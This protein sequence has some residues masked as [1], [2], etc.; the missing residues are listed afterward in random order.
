M[1]R[2]LGAG[3]IGVT[4]PFDQVVAWAAEFGFEGVSVPVDLAVDKG[5]EEVTLPLQKHKIKP[6]SFGLPVEYRQDADVFKKEVGALPMKAEIAAQIG[7]TRCT[8]WVLPGRKGISDADYFNEL[9]DRLGECAKILHDHGIRIGFEYLGPKTL[10]DGLGMETEGINTAEKMMELVEA[11]GI[12]GTGLLLDSW[13]WY[14]A[15]EDTKVFD[16]LNNRLVIAVHV[17]DAPRD[18]AIDEQ[19]DN[20]RDL[21]GATG[22]IDLDGFF[23]GLKKIEYDGPV[24]VEPFKKELNDMDDREAVAKTSDALKKFV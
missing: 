11:I 9:L 3:A 21:P 12:P 19:I 16:G 24:M 2:C 17:N 8:T 5:I 20:I 7:L 15:H 14:T 13:H 18:K 10:R 6:A 4:A 23:A 22:V 1:Y